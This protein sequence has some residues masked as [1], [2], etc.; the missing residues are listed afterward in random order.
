MQRFFLK[1]RYAPLMSFGIFFLVASLLIRLV[2][3][4]WSFPDN[5]HGLGQTLYTFLIGF[6]FD[7]G[8][9]S[10]F[11]FPYAFY[12]LIFPK[13]WNGTLTDKILTYFFMGFM[14]FIALFSFLAELAFWDE[15]K[16]RFNFIAVDYLI[17]TYEVVKNI[18]ESYPLPIL[19]G[20]IFLLIA[21]YFFIH[22]KK[23]V[24]KEAFKSSTNLKTRFSTS[25]LLLVIALTYYWFVNNKDAER[26][27]N[28]YNNEL[29]KSGIYSFFSAFKNNELS[30][31]QFYN[32]LS[33]DEAFSITQQLIVKPSDSLLGDSFSIKRFVKNRDSLNQSIKPNVILIC[34]ESL[35]GKLLN[36]LGGD[37]NITPFL[38]S[39]AQES[40]FFENLYAT[41][42]RTVRGMEALMLSV[43]PTPGR[44][45][46]KRTNSDH[47]FTIGN[48]F[49]EKGYKNTFFYGGDGYFDN[50][51]YFFGSSGFNIVDRSRGFFE[52]ESISTQHQSIQDNEVSF[53]NAW[54]VCDE[55]LYNKVMAEADKNFVSKTPFFD[56]VMTTSNH[57]PF[58]Y[59]DGKVD[60][61]SGKNRAGAVKYT[62]YALKEFFNKARNKPWFEHTVFIIVSDH[63]ASSA[64]R[65]A[66]DVDKYQIVGMIYNF[67]NKDPMKV[68]ALASQIDV[69]PTLFGLL[70]WDYKSNFYGQNILETP[71]LEQ[72]A[73]LG[74]YRKLG[75]MD[76]AH[77]LTILSEQKQSNQFFWQQETDSL[78]PQ[79]T[80]SLN[81][82]KAIS[83]YQTADYL[84]H[85][86]K[87]K[88]D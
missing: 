83:L 9:L 20:G 81:L 15:F 69:L 56:F 68:S 43:P 62:D 36:S 86:G 4:I 42:T 6:F 84:Y 82:K 26:F 79:P 66:I 50:M 10:F 32:S 16:C 5:N 85:E 72:R 45:I 52:E 48:V 21:L 87:L 30:Y 49:A 73:L 76:S 23:G 28:R 37:Y 7:L 41:G 63:C 60:I 59:P 74:N 2:L 22:F 51:N 11:V 71:V 33:N 24:F 29:A 3:F 38:D 80:D 40:I 14:V 25:L 17:Y 44:S 57:K 39:L 55:D 64:G 27:D 18:N 46:I 67:P 77:K 70:N 53:E 12:L 61:P 47:L 1:N 31:L 88:L 8:T 54:G 13:K 65:W 35:S 34:V 58:T 78:L 75:Y 19:L